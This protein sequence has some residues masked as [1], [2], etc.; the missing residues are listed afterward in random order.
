MTQPQVG[1]M[2]QGLHSN[3]SETITIIDYFVPLKK[4]APASFVPPVPP[5]TR[6]STGNWT[7]L[8]SVRYDFVFLIVVEIEEQCEIFSW[9]QGIVR[10]LTPDANWNYY[11]QMHP[12]LKRIRDPCASSP[13]PEGSMCVRY[14]QPVFEHFVTDLDFYICTSHHLLAN[15]GFTK[16]YFK[17]IYDRWY[18]N[19]P[20]DAKTT[21]ESY[22]EALAF[23]IE[24]NCASLACYV[25]S[26]V[27]R[28]YLRDDYYPNAGGLVSYDAHFY[29][30]PICE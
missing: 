25:L 14:T 7:L 15:R 4:I 1:R 11:V 13:C 8:A 10:K 6:R 26:S 17:I 23:C 28:C 20:M 18:Y 30:Q 27:P 24:F 2:K 9:A 22:K 29:F 16:C 3:S 5:T 21:L 19:Y 12:P